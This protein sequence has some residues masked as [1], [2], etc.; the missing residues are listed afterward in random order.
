VDGEAK[1]SPATAEQ[2][3]ASAKPT[4]P[5]APPTPAAA[6]ATAT[7]PDLARTALLKRS[8][9]AEIVG[10]TDMRQLSTFDKPGQSA[11]GVEP[12]DCAMKLMFQESLAAYDYL[13]A[14]GDQNVGAGGQLVSQLI[15]VFPVTNKTWPVPNRQALRV[16][17]TNIQHLY[18][19]QCREGTEFTTTAKDVTQ[20]WTAGPVTSENPAALDDQ[21]QDTARGG[22]GIVRQEGPRETVITQSWPAAT[23]SSNRL[24]AAVDSQAQANQVI[25]RISAKLPTG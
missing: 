1:Q 5:A 8:E 9:L 12:R 6:P 17:S 3:S 7:T 16:A 4:T 24:C 2:T 13:A 14:T 18:D 19:E 11:A 25:Y 20:H 23:R 15:Q 10:D 22:A 21:R